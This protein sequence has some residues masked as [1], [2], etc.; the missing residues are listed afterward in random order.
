MTPASYSAESAKPKWQAQERDDAVASSIAT[1]LDAAA[2]VSAGLTG[3]TSSQLLPA[4]N[5]LIPFVQPSD[6]S[7]LHTPLF[8]LSARF[9][10]WRA[11]HWAYDNSTRHFNWIETAAAAATT[12]ATAAAADSSGPR[13]GQVMLLLRA[14]CSRL[15]PVLLLT[16]HIHRSSFRLH[17]RGW[18]VGL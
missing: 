14:R 10:T 2:R 17:F 16:C 8:T 15:P 7:K 11:A 6:T 3:V 1:Q 18:W 9:K 13:L 4:L 5:F 12:T